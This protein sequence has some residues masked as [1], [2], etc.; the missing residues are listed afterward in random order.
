VQ[1]KSCLFLFLSESNFSQIKYSKSHPD[2]HSVLITYDEETT[3]SG[4]N[5]IPVWKFKK[6]LKSAKNNNIFTNIW[7]F[8]QNYLILTAKSFYVYNV[9][10]KFPN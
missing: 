2:W 3:V 8:R 10:V 1:N 7:K 4:I 5:V 9:Q 6:I